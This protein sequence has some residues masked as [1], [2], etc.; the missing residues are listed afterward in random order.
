MKIIPSILEDK[1]LVYMDEASFN[2]CMV[3]KRAW[4]NIGENIFYPTNIKSSNYSV[5]AAITSSEVVGF[6]VV[7]DSVTWDHF[8]YFMEFCYH[9]LVIKYHYSRLIFLY[10]GAKCHTSRASQKYF[11]NHVNA[12]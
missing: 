7:K 1:V 2:L 12:I 3:K 4:I 10:D 8:V 6:Q 5:I 9:H 11:L